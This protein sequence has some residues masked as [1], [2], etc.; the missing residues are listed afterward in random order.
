[1]SEMPKLSHTRSLPVEALVELYS[2]VGWTAYTRDAP[3][4]A[5]AVA[6]STYV[7]SAWEEERLVGLARCLSDDLAVCYIQDVLVHSALQRRGVGRL[8][9]SDCLERFAHVRMKILL[10]DDEARQYAFYTSLGFTDTRE[11]EGAVLRTFVQF[12]RP[13]PSTPSEKNAAL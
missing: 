5:Q 2:A 13:S 3:G 7:V 9:L 11:F 4:L 8:L 10:T 1:M 6:N 12:R